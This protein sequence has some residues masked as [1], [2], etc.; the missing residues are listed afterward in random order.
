MRSER[1][2][3]LLLALSLAGCG[4]DDDR[5]AA[6]PQPG[7]NAAPTIS[8]VP[9]V[10]ADEDAAY[11]F[12]P[13]AADADGDALTFAVENAPAWAS[14]DAATGTLSGTPTRADVG[15][16]GD[17]RITVSDSQASATLDPFAIEVVQVWNLALAG[18]ALDARSPTPS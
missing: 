14:F 9:P 18:A 3:V 8:G 1:L 7:P 15:S 16:H 11:T 4:S 5:G 13:D 17:V 2:G 12:T 10:Q 6:P